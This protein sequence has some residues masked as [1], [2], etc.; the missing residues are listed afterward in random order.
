MQRAWSDVAY[1]AKDSPAFRSHPHELWTPQT[2][3]QPPKMKHF[4]PV[5]L[6]LPSRVFLD[7]SR[8]CRFTALHPRCISSAMYARSVALSVRVTLV[9]TRH[10]TCSLDVLDPLCGIDCESGSTRSQ[11][12]RCDDLYGAVVLIRCASLS[13]TF[14]AF[15]TL[16]FALYVH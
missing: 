14:F 16:L 4:E 15:V 13:G 11:T 7:V 2:T 9:F 12:T 10:C 8:V 1:G 6:D 3:R 5:I